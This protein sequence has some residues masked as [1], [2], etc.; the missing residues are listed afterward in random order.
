MKE[1]N[2][3]DPKIIEMIAG[4]NDLILPPDDYD[5][6]RGLKYFKNQRTRDSAIFYHKLAIDKDP[7]QFYYLKELVHFLSRYPVKDE[8]ITQVINSNL[9]N[10]TG[11]QQERLKKYLAR[12][13]KSK[14]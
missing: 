10:Y 3:S 13:D 8:E 4:G 14:K 2:W 11:K 7:T 9:L 1:V 5:E 12:F 6:G